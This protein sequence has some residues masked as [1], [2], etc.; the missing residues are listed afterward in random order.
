MNQK[1]ITDN[2]LLDSQLAQEIYAEIENLPIIDYHSHLSAKEIYEDYNY[3]TITEMWLKADHYKW[4]QMRTLGISEALITS[5][6]D[7]FEQFTA[8]AKTLDYAIGNPLYHWS[9]LELKRFFQIDQILSEKSAKEIYEKANVKL[10]SGNLSV[11]NLIKMANVKM[12]GTT[13][14]ICDDL[15]YHQKIASDSTIDFQVL[16]TFRPD[17]YV[18]YHEDY[19]ESLNQL[20]AVVGYSIV[21]F[22]QFLS[23]LNNRLDYFATHGCVISDHGISKFKY[24][25]TS[26]EEC[27]MIFDKII[28][29]IKLT[30]EQAVQFNSFLLDYLTCEYQKRN[31]VL[32]LHL[33]ATR[34]NN[35][36]L[37]QKLGSDIG[38]DAISGLNYID[39]VTYYLTNNSCKRK[40]PKIIIY[41]LNPRDN[42]ALMAM[43]G[44]FQ[45]V[46]KGHLQ[47]GSAWWFNDHI[48]GIE[49]HLETHQ[50]LGLLRVFIGMLTDSRSFL[51][52][53]R[54]EYF[55]RILA[56]HLAN[57]VVKGLY[58]NDVQMLKQIAV[59]ISYENAKNY[60]DLEE[61]CLN[62]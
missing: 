40:L 12:I 59:E 35:Q 4:R 20:S 37:A 47:L 22:A 8:Y 24:K 56:N 3:Q 50:A 57:L 29:K 33:G 17:K 7:E 25:V 31:W 21:D 11:R 18:I 34:N 58:P 53:V 61:K 23:A 43:I 54:H 26:Y 38:C 46:S 5:P 51:S 15:M 62:N 10:A 42:D 1:F 60:F 13:D 32:Q 41:N 55:R 49:N 6:Q 45:G 19:L 9:H 36:C 2:F 27:V 14:D 39:D 44:S 28:S 48:R 52:F 16:P 30:T